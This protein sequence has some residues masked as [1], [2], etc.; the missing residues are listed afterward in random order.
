MR[1]ASRGFDDPAEKV[2]RALGFLKFAAEQSSNRGTYGQI[3]VRE[4]RRHGTRDLADVF[5]DDLAELNTPFYFGEFADLLAANGLQFL[6]EAELHAMGT[7]DMTPAAREFISGIDDVI[8]REQYLD[9]FR[10]RAFR[11][12]LVVHS[13]VILDRDMKPNVLDRLLISS[14]L[15]P[16]G[17]S[18]DLAGNGRVK[19]AGNSGQSIEIDMPLAKIAL[20]RLGSIWPRAVAFMELSAE[21]REQAAGLSDD[22]ADRQSEAFRQ[23]LFQIATATDLV[24]LH[25]FQPAASTELSEKPRLSRLA[26]WQM[27]RARNVISG[28]GV[29]ME[30]A[31]PVSRRLLELLDGKRSRSA[32]LDEL[33]K[34]IRSSHE[35]DG[36]KE[37]LATLPEWLD[38]SLAH[39]ARL[40]MFEG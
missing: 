22:E 15:R 16:A 30:I 12:S 20:A 25:S 11:Q 7:A 4:F 24:E 17:K 10:G 37:L 3:L 6:A 40:G 31:D 2:E 5:H 34:F 32:V 35:I 18:P 8:E 33:G 26:R 21:A 39:L 38:E 13:D 23:M 28:F 36:K 14:S 19:F 29:D 1:F 27:R 9:I